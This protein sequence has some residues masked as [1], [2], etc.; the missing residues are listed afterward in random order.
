MEN[1]PLVVEIKGKMEAGGYFQPF[2]LGGYMYTIEKSRTF[3]DELKI[4]DENRELLLN[5]HLEINPSMIPQ[6][7]T[8]SLRLAELQKQ[9]QPDITAIGACI[10]DIMG[11]LFG[12]TN[13]EKIIA[14]YEN[15]YTQ[16]LYDIF[17]YI[18]Q[19]IVPEIEKLAK[20]RKKM[21][22]KKWR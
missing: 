3:D 20:D 8:L 15:N 2:L 12:K 14:F 19:V 21:F 6:Y 11:L 16:M 5:I 9:P 7:R 18:Q 22:S 13:T 10:V 1:P 17:P 4:T